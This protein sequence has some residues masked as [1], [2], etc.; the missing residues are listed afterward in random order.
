[1]AR[2]VRLTIALPAGARGWLALASVLALGSVAATLAID[3][4][5]VRSTALDWQPWRA[6]VDPWRALSAAFVHHSTLHL[7]ANLA[8]TVLVAALGV[9][10]RVPPAAAWAWLA[11]WP[12]TQI[13]LLLRPDLAHYGGLS[14]VLHA[15]VAIV[16][17]QLALE[18]RGPRRAIGFAL[19][20]GL[21][22][23]ALLEAPWGPALRHPA[24]WDIATAPFAHASGVVVG[25]FC[26]LAARTLERMQVVDTL[27]GRSAR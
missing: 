2:G 21:V 8:G 1:V 18:A 15:G 12:L 13:G 14:G 17:L 23:K 3:L 19:G 20:A 7:G 6:S 24:G 25:A 27:R 9:V 22:L 4:E 10:G 26:A 5:L 11:A 16:A